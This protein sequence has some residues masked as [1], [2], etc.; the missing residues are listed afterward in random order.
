MIKGYSY[1]SHKIASEPAEA[2]TWSQKSGTS[3]L[4]ILADGWKM[5]GDERD[6]KKK[7]FPLYNAN[8]WSDHRINL[9]CLVD[10]SKVFC[11]YIS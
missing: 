6:V 3:K 11:H 7:A 2:T 10:S 8:S 4:K 1:T 9:F 5:R